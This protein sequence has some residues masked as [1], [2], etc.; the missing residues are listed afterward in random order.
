MCYSVCGA[1][2]D[3]FETHKE[4]PNHH[5]L[6]TCRPGR[7]VWA[8]KEET[9]GGLRGWRYWE[10]NRAFFL[11]RLDGIDVFG[12]RGVETV[13]E[14]LCDDV[15]NSLNTLEQRKWTLVPLRR[16]QVAADHGLSKQMGFFER[17]IKMYLLGEAMMDAF[18]HMRSCIM[19]FLQ[20]IFFYPH[21]P[22]FFDHFFVDFQHKAKKWC[23]F[24]ISFVNRHSN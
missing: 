23:F 15:V 18:P 14:V 11:H 5:S 24:I 21:P 12:E 4:T 1:N 19:L 16:F 10:L 13:N 9:R 6:F 8:E 3:G 7:D 17:V 22:P 2:I 20:G